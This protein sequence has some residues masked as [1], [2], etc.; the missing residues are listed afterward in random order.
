M[1]DKVSSTAIGALKEGWFSANLGRTT[2]YK[3]VVRWLVRVDGLS[4]AT[5]AA[6]IVLWIRSAGLSNVSLVADP[7]KVA[8]L[9][10]SVG[11][12]TGLLNPFGLR[13]SLVVRVARTRAAV[14]VRCAD[15]APLTR[16]AVADEILGLTLSDGSSTDIC[17]ADPVVTTN[18][19]TT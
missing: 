4:Q 7:V 5:R 17:S 8:L 18:H 13:S 6:V 14:I 9:T 2:G 19:S 1:N 11:L 12:S 10:L 3:P 16:D 15:L